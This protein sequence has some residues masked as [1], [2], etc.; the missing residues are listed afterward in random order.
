VRNVSSELS[1]ER[2]AK[3]KTNGRET[4]PQQPQPNWTTI[5]F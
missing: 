1:Q 3:R 2:A 5:I 4:H